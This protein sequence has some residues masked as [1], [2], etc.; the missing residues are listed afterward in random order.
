MLTVQFCPEDNETSRKHIYYTVCTSRR[1]VN[2]RGKKRF[3]EGI[4]ENGA[5][6]LE[7]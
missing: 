7:Q 2:D 6:M 3:E 5:M 4:A 1:V